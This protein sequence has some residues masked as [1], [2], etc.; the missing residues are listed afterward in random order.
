[1]AAYNEARIADHIYKTAIGAGYYGNALHVAKYLP[2][3]TPQEQ[4]AAGSLVG[5]AAMVYGPYRF[6]GLGEQDRQC[7]KIQRSIGK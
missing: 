1:M 4:K 5:W 2:Y 7:S 3:L 6:A